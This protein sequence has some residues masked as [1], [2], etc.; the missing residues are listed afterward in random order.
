MC[1]IVH[2]STTS[3]EDL[4][5]LPTDNYFIKRAD[6]EEED[7]HIARLAHPHKWFLMCR[8][9]GCS[10]HFRHCNVLGNGDAEFLTP[11][12]DEL[13]ANNDDDEYIEDTAAVYDLLTRLSNE[14]HKVDLLD[15]WNGDDLHRIK[16]VEVS[17]SHVPREAFRFF[18]GYRFE[19][20]P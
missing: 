4:A 6:E 19:I 20:K 1:N 5:L 9:G 17:L 18:E 12:E 14:G 2:I 8:Y 11:E 10:C 16:T 3:E 15:S 7:A 13:N